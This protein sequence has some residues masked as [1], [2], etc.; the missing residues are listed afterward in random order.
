MVIIFIYIQFLNC[1][2]IYCTRYEHGCLQIVTG[3]I[4]KPRIWWAFAH[5]HLEGSHIRSSWD[6]REALRESL[7]ILQM[8]ELRVK[9]W[10]DP[11]QVTRVVS[12]QARGSVN[13]GPV[14]HAD[15]D[16]YWQGLYWPEVIKSSAAGTPMSLGRSCVPLPPGRSPSVTSGRPTRAY[17]RWKA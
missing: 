3:P 16:S 7:S 17:E 11:L 9:R 8:R 13:P 14:P 2:G 15:W 10:Q 5:T 12:S 6:T 1:I 4:I